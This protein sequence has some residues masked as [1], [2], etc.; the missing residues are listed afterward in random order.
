MHR[1]GVL[2]YNGVRRAFCVHCMRVRMCIQACLRKRLPT[3]DAHH[4]EQTTG[5]GSPKMAGQPSLNCLYS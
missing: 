1:D 3:S 5:V 2:H 4:T